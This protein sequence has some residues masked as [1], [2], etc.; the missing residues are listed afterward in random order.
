M[1]NKQFDVVVIGNVGIDTNIYLDGDKID[2]QIE[3]N[4]TENVDYVGQAGG[5][6]AR[7][8]AQLGYHTAFIGY[9]GDDHLG[10]FILEEFEKDGINTDGIF[11]DPAGTN[12]SI[13]FMYKNGRRKNFY[14][15]KS[16]MSLTP[17]SAKCR[18]LLEK[19]RLAHFNIPNW[20]R[21]LLPVAKESGLKISCDIQ[22][23]AEFPD[24]YR[25]DFIDY[26]D[27][28]FLSGVNHADP[29]PLLRKIT[30][31]HPQKIVICGMGAQGCA[32]GTQDGIEYFEVIEIPGKIVDTNGA[33]DGLAVG[34]LSGY[35][36]EKSGIEE[37]IFRAQIVA[38][39]TCTLK[40]TTSHLISQEIQQK[41]LTR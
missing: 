31:K 33:G 28:I 36:F 37:S 27:V 14:D 29:T 16:H 39:Y 2:F 26:A 1:I 17:D 40:A 7:G 20:A 8:F 4:F 41:L 38:R 18:A 12:R 11:I 30:K 21:H 19:S 22:D 23:V 13:N 9:I 25:S 24:P 35:Y 34:F 15:G 5:Y 32:V 10:R 3:S 6:A